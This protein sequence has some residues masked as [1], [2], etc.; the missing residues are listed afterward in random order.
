M[1]FAVG[2]LVGLLVATAIIVRW[3][4]S[5]RDLSRYSDEEEEHESYLYQDN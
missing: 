1:L 5:I 3:V 4:Q 2:F